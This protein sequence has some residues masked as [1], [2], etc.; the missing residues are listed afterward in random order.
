MGTHGTRKKSQIPSNKIA[1]PS[2]R[3]DNSRCLHVITFKTETVHGGF[4]E[5][6][7]MIDENNH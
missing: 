1:A 5:V 3:T 2:S 4:I 6:R 7:T